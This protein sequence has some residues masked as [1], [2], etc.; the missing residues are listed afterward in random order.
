MRTA[1]SFSPRAAA[2]AALGLLVALA[3]PASALDEEYHTRLE[4]YD[5][6]VATA[7][8]YPSICRMDT[9]GYSTEEGLPIWALKMSDNV[10]IDED[11]P[12]ILYD[13][14]HHADEVLGL[15]VCLYMIDELAA[16]YGVDS[17]MTAWVSDCEIW[18]IPLLNPEGHEI[19]TAEIDT[20]WRKNKRDNNE[21][22]E[23]DYEDGVDPNRNYDFNW[24]QGGSDIPESEYYRGPYPF[25]EGET[26]AMRDFC[27]AHKPVFALN[28]HSPRSSQG[29]LVYYPWYWVGHGFSKDH[30]TIFDV[31]S[32]LCSRTY[33]EAGQ[34]FIAYYGYAD[35][36]NARNWQYGIA[37]TI[38]LTM[39]ILSEQCQP[40]GSRVDTICRLVSTG[41]YYL[42]ERSY[43]PGITG[44]VTDAVTRQPLVAEVTVVENYSELVVPRTTDPTYGR[45]WR[46]LIPGTY[47]VEFSA[48]GYDTQVFEGVVVDST[49]LTV[50]DC[51]M[52]AWTGMPEDQ[53][54]TPRIVGVSPNPSRGATTVSFLAPPGSPVDVDIYSVT[55]RLVA[56]AESETDGVRGTASWNGLDAAGRPVASGIYFARLDGA[57]P[58]DQAKIVLVR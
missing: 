11:E 4:T 18:F 26:Q 15:E 47:T 28:Y 52:S 7:T 53:I 39:E 1:E 19:V 46:M 5:A 49:G 16:A 17:T 14:V 10:G 33:N 13:G 27:L 48:F 30:F 32:Q 35:N 21:N 22:G 6:L 38:G 31:A 50:L 44:H 54:E 36:G 3:A 29:D 51:E 42:V 24:D 41:S 34:N 25:S 45:Y 20:I 55:G 9:L 23:W 57:F 37:G 8:S 12:V 56:R 2:L 40:V 43:G 58:A